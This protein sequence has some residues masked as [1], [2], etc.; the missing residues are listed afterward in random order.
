MIRFGVIGL[1]FMGRTHLASL[2]AH[3]GAEVVSVHDVEAERLAGPLTPGGGNI[4]TASGAWDASSVRRCERLEEVLD[5]PGVEAVVVATPS[6]LHADLSCAALSA[7]KH[8]FCEKPMAL[9][10]ADCDRMLAAAKAAG[11]QLM[12]GHCIRFWGEYAEAARIARSGR[13][14]PVKSLTLTRYGSIPGFGAR[15]WFHDPAK[16]GAAVLDLHIHDVDYALFVLGE[17]E[18]V[19]AR[20]V[21]G[22]AGGYHQVVAE[23]DY[24]PEGPVVSAEGGWLPGEVPFQ[25]EFR[26]CLEKATVLYKLR[27]DGPKGRLYV[28]GESD[29]RA[30]PESNAYAAE[31]DHFIGCVAGGRPSTIVPPGSSRDS[32]AVAIAE[33]ESIRTGRAVEIH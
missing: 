32:V 23:L 16:S 7:G 2:A 3:E 17:P 5:D 19:R 9:T 28:A 15:N 33:T 11:R 12:I 18:A 13:Y 4:E 8:V 26:M 25:M 20:G 31:I 6:H 21:P 30:L 14:G 1:G 27:T 10:V 24:G 22:P 29:P